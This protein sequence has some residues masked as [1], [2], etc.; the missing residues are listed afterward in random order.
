M[1][2]KLQAYLLKEPP[3]PGSPM[4]VFEITG[5]PP[6][7]S[8]V[9]MVRALDDIS[10]ALDDYAARAAETGK[11]LVVSALKHRGRAVAGF[12]KVPDADRTRIV[13]DHTLLEV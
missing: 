13:N 10:A 3:R 4:G 9:T 11:P 7:P 1:I 8:E 6:F 5:R 12:N 2:I